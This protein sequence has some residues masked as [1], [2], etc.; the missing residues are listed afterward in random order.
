MRAT[1]DIKTGLMSEAIHLN[2][3]YL[4]KSSTNHITRRQISNTKKGKRGR[5]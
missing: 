5:K 2:I 1:K 3:N 4:T